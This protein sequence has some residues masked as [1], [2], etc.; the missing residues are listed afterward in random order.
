MYA[1]LGAI[2]GDRSR[3]KDLLTIKNAS[4]RAVLDILQTLQDFS[5]LGLI[6]RT[7]C[8][9][10]LV[11]LASAS[12]QFPPCLV[13][14][15]V[16]RQEKFA[17][18]Y[19]SHS[20]I[21]KG[22]FQGRSVAVRTLRRLSSSSPSITKI[23]K[24]FAVEAVIWGRL[25]HPSILPFYGVHL[26][27]CISSFVSPWM[28][29][30]N[31]VQFLKR[32]LHPDRVTLILDIARGLEYLHTGLDP[33][34]IHGDLKGTKV[35]ITPS[36]R[37]CLSGFA[38]SR[39]QYDL[40]FLP[41]ESTASTSEELGALR[42]TAPELLHFGV[43]SFAGD[44][45]A[46]ACTIYQ[47]FSGKH[48][49]HEFTRNYPVVTSVMEGKRPARPT[50]ALLDDN[51][52]R[53]VEACWTQQPNDRPSATQIVQRL[54]TF[55]RRRGYVDQRPV[56]EWDNPLEPNPWPLAGHPFSAYSPDYERL[57]FQEQEETD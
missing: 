45:Y 2:I 48:P 15:G 9:T 17:V 52:W 25:C 6:S 7:K 49:F 43:P 16:T 19:G 51:I 41:D 10:A 26:D 57:Y 29:H 12:T 36:K 56:D 13:I 39:Y 28:E 8:A 5:S 50:E 53:L 44:V 55:T 42:W 38:L 27:E 46:F 22:N 18:A 30:G 47:I 11:Q 21:F 33:N 40:K 34:I 14:R 3:Y 20:D 37:A 31:I 4:A 24:A 32:D 23:L 35:L 54:V 1:Q